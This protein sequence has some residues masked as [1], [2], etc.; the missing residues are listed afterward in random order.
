[1]PSDGLSSQVFDAQE[2]EA[3]ARR[4][5]QRAAR[6]STCDQM[7]LTGRAHPSLARPVLLAGASETLEKLIIGRPRGRP[8]RRFKALNTRAQRRLDR[9]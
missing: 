3:C 4:P 1:M 7:L 8:G 6:N 9:H 2:A 5:N